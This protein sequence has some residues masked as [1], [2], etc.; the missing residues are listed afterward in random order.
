MN[1]CETLGRLELDQQSAFNEQI[2]AK[3]LVNL[4]AV[5]ANWNRLLSLNGK[6]SLREALTQAN[7]INLFE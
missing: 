2:G 4:Q 3:S 5:E 6:A 7:F 1:R